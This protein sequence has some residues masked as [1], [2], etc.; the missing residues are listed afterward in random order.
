MRT[1]RGKID[2]SSFFVF[3]RLRVFFKITKDFKGYKH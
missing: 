2:N 3:S 1:E